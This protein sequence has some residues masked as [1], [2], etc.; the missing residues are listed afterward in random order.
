MSTR[1]RG[2]EPRV[3]RALH[4]IARI[5]GSAEGSEAR[6]LRVLE[7]L[8]QLVPYEQCALL[9]A[10]P[11]LA[12]RILVAP[13]A[14]P[15]ERA[16]LTET[17]MLLFGRLVDEHTRAP[18]APPRPSGPHLAV[19]LVELD[20]VIG[21]LLVRSVAGAYTAGHLRALS[22]VGAQLAAYLTLLRVRAE[23]ADR[24]RALDEA[25]SAAEA[26]NRTK[27]EFLALVSHELKTPLTTV[28]AWAHVLGASDLAEAERA[29]A[30]D[31]IEHSVGA[32]TKLIEE[33]LDL[34]CIATARLRLDVRAVDPA[35]LIRAA[36]EGIR[37]SAE[38]RSIRVEAA[39]DGSVE[40]LLVDPDRLGQVVENL[41]ANAVKFTPTGGNVEVRLERAGAHA[42]IRVIDSGKG[43]RHELLPHVFESFRQA[44]STTTRSHGGLG[45]GLALVKNLVE[46]H[47]GRVHAESPG[48]EKGAT[49]TVELPLAPEAPVHP[50]AAGARTLTG[51]R[52]LLVD[53][54]ES[55]RDAVQVVLERHGAEVRAVGSAAA[56]LEVLGEWGPDVLL[57]DL[58]M[59]GES[60]YDLMRKAAA[61][62]PALPA[63]ALTAHGREVEREALAAGFRV[64]LAK[65]IE[66]RTLVGAIAGLAGRSAPRG[67]EAAKTA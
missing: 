8:R 16:R 37:R 21:V 41:L 36:I 32:Q 58:A 45:V 5:L 26:A 38:Q 7:L 33:I 20:E 6:V 4:D 23:E 31:A 27:D 12:P 54:D 22:V 34:A 43:I 46:L 11:G 57:S 13:P 42:R 9:E 18:E 35:S 52:V 56:A 28:L 44:D 39:L 29:R 65:P 40:R 10:Q 30:V 17:L 62:D 59:P 3:G 14:P 51:I 61:H 64:V 53:D 66:A 50:R 2:R 55:V 67:A 19:P 49:F 1:A 24:A 15:D 47:G 48:E 60:G 25:R 63:A